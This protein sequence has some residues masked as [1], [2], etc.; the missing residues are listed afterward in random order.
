MVV[1][2]GPRIV[3]LWAE[4]RRADHLGSSDQS[5]KKS[6]YELVKEKV[7][8]SLNGPVRLLTN[9]R[10]L[11]YVM[12][13]VS[14]YFCFDATGSQVIAVVAEVHNTP[15][16]EQHCYVLRWPNQTTEKAQLSTEKCFHVSPF[17]PMDMTYKWS[18]SKPDENLSDWNQQLSG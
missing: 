13:P 4:F 11:G 6:V 16:G 8:I 7:G 15:W 17:F 12:N 9:L 2:F 1:G 14:F 10:Y 18:L 3:V 5:L